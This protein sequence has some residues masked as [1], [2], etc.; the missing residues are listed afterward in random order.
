MPWRKKPGDPPA[1]VD[2]SPRAETIPEKIVEEESG[3]FKQRQRRR[4]SIAVPILTTRRG[5]TVSIDS[6]RSAASTCRFACDA[7]RAVQ[8]GDLQ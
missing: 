3:E 6:C 7:R 4:S 1:R 2:F 8:C 5:S